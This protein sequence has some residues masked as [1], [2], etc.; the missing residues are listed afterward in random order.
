MNV[1][2]TP[3]L[4]ATRER[5]GLSQSQLAKQLK[6]PKATLA[7]AEI[8]QR[9]LPVAALLKV[10]E[11]ELKIIA[12][13]QVP[14]TNSR[15]LN[16][17]EEPQ[18]AISD[19]MS[20]REDECQYEIWGCTRRLVRMEEEYE[21]LIT[22]LQLIKNMIE[23]EADKP[24]ND[25]MIELKYQEMRIVKRISNCGISQQN[26]LRTRIAVLS[27]ESYITNSAKQ[28]LVNQQESSM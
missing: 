3:G 10:A 11:L 24:E 16:V 21:K 20:A 14:F 25:L 12:A 22:Q 27:A 7:M 9:S 18:K 19:F 8:G 1:Q 13:S 5:L 23:P 6:I 28:Q 26:V 4:A 17:E 15:G 2:S